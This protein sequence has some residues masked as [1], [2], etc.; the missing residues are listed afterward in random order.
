MAQANAPLT[1][2]ELGSRGPRIR[3]ELG[4][5]QRSC[6]SSASAVEPLMTLRVPLTDL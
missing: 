5:M 1:D 6:E 3:P 4:R 2:H